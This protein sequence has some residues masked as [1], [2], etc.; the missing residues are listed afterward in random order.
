MN[1]KKLLIFAFL[2]VFLVIL[3]ESYCATTRECGLPFC[4]SKVF[5][6]CYEVDNGWTA[7]EGDKTLLCGDGDTCVPLYRPW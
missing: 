2:I 3:W 6:K 5:Q 1:K 4:S 7:R